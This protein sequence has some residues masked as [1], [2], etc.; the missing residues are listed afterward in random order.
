M[1]SEEKHPMLRSNPVPIRLATILSILVT[2]AWAGGVR[3]DACSDDLSCTFNSCRTP[4]SP[5]PSTLWGEL[6]PAE[7]FIPAERDT[8][9]F[10]GFQTYNAER[11]YWMA[12]DVEDGY[13]FTAINS[14]FEIWDARSSPASPVLRSQRDGRAGQ[15]LQFPANPEFKFPIQDIDVPN[16]DSNVM[17][18]VGAATTGLSIWNTTDKSSPR[19]LYQDYGEKKDGLA[20]YAVTIG[21]RQLAFMASETAGLLAYDIT[22]AKSLTGPCAEQSPGGQCTGVY[23]GKVGGR[24]SVSYVTGAGNFVAISSGVSP[25]GIEIY[26]ASQPFPTLVASGLTNE[27]VY[28]MAMWQEGGTIYLATRGAAGQQ[29]NIYDVSCLTSGACSSIGSPISSVPTPDP[30]NVRYY[31]T[32]SRSG[33]T[34]FLYLGSDRTCLG[35]ERREWLFDVSSPFAPRDVSP[36]DA[37]HNGVVT[38]Y[39]NWYYRGTATGFNNV[40]PRK[41]RFIGDHLYRAAFA[42]F[43]I[44][45]RGGGAALP[46]FTWSPTEIYPG[47]PVSFI[48]Q[49]SGSPTSW[50]WSFP[51]G[52][53]SSSTARNPSGVVYADAGTKNVSLQVCNGQGCN[54]VTRNVEV[55]SPAASVSSVTVSPTVVDVCGTVVATANGVSGQAPL[56]ISWAIRDSGGTVVASCSTNPC[57]WSPGAAASSG[58]YTATVTVTNSFNPGGAS[59]S[60]GFTVTNNP[61]SFIT[62]APTADPFTGTTVKFRSQTTGATEWAWDFDDDNNAATIVFGPYSS[63]AVNGP[64]P[65]HTY[66][67]TGQKSVRVRIRNCFGQT[68]DSNA[69]VINVT[70]SAPLTAG[71]QAQVCLFGICNAVVNQPVTFTDYS[72][73]SP[74]RWNYHWTNTGSSEAGCVFSGLGSTSPQTTNTFTTAG[75][76]R[77]C[78]RVTRG[79]TSDIYVHPPITVAPPGGTPTIAIVGPS[80]GQAGETLTFSATAQNCTPSSTGWTWT[81]DG[82]VGTSTSSSI[83]VTWNTTGTKTI[84]A[85]NSACGSASGTRSVSISTSGAGALVASFTYAPST[86]FTG[87]TVTFNAS[88]SLGSPTAYTWQWGDGT[89]STDGLIVTHSFQ[90]AGTY[91]VKLIVARPGQ[92]AGCSFGFCYAEKTTEVVVQP[93]V[94]G[95]CVSDPTSLCLGSNR[96][97][98]EVDWTTPDGMSGTGKPVPITDDTGYFWFFDVKNVEVVVKTLDGCGVNGNF[99]VFAAGLTDVATEMTVTDTVTGEVNTYSNPQKTAFLPVQDTSA[100]SCVSA[101]TVAFEGLSTDDGGWIEIEEGEAP[102]AGRRYV[103]SGKLSPLPEATCEPTNTAM[104]LNKGRFRVEATWRTSDGRSGSGQGIPL[105]E[106]TGYFWFFNSANVEIVLKVL[107]GCEINNRY[108]V[109]A[110]GLT[111]VEVSIRVSDVLAGSY[112]TYVNPQGVAFAPIQ[113]TSFL[114]FCP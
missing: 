65:T 1:L 14:G 70:G 62:P 6:Q 34:P 98:I 23:L 63:D 105:T 13:V 109:F 81:T 41:A 103:V 24:S 111:D 58:S 49:S 28:G 76:F 26:D 71:F 45:R 101:K 112:R 48:D 11:P 89:P 60:A 99:W 87:Q 91:P 38:R 88:S 106:D 79:S 113:D 64:S 52:N 93:A 77:P 110:G 18:L 20:V 68:L 12:I 97:K 4:A 114:P 86:V 73:G 56:A 108:W 102:P 29:L 53:P 39:W 32:F 84:A 31:V 3:A 21:S 92:G 83:N 36:Q 94:T 82:G 43:D 7:G 10:Q 2:L 69:L 9:D 33:A 85:T 61:L 8:T 16:G 90:N 47:T 19:Q 30:A 44:H 46:N 78:L 80:G 95:S 57:A 42:I 74:E 5:A 22:K 55:R 100:Y 37:I 59:A 67:T 72:T 104:C 15:F 17:A 27:I 40:G 107:D 35:S 54:S 51:G 66:T 96:F 50:S 25:R 75:T